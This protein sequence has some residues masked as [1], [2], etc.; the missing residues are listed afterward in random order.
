MNVL[1]EAVGSPGWPTLKPWLRSVFDR[2]IALELD[3]TVARANLVDACHLVPPHSG[4]FDAEPIFEICRREGVDVVLPSVDEG[5]A[6][7]AAQ[8]ETFAERGVEVVVSPAATVEIFS[9][10]WHTYRFFVEH[11]DRQLRPA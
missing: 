6:F 5:L 2:I 8:R 1:V 9:D 11:V 7:W 10:K 4:L 3:E